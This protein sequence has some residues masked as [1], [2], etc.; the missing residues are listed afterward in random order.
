[1]TTDSNVYPIDDL[2]NRS[3]FISKEAFIDSHYLSIQKEYKQYIDKA[4]V[5]NGFILDRVEQLARNILIENTT[6]E[7]VFLVIMKGALVFSNYLMKF[8]AEIK[9]NIKYEGLIYFEYLSSSSYSNDSSTG[10]VKITDSNDTLKRLKGKNVIIVEDIYDSGL[11]LN[12]LINNYLVNCEL[13]SL[14]ITCLFLKTNTENLK[15]DLKI[16]YI[17]FTIPGDSFI[18]GFGIDYNE[19]FRDLKHCCVVSE[20][21]I[22]LLKK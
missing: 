17:G 15:Y 6:K 2:R 20:S 13:A 4:I 22:K 5:S 21:G 9:D 12:Y 16:D 14:K 19:L 1:M 7:I 8:I 18:V 10:E 11:S 3:I